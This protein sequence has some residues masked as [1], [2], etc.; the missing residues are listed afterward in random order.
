MNALSW[1]CC[2][3]KI[4]LGA[5]AHENIEGIVRELGCTRLFVAVDEALLEGELFTTGGTG[6]EVSGSCVITDTEKNLKM[7]IRHA[8]FN[9]ADVAILDPLA[10]RTLPAHVAA[11][12]ALTR[13]S[14][15]SKAT[16]RC[17]PTRSPTR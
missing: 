17:R 14:M 11:H 1:Y 15:R 12:S 7:S 5:G 8:Q 16:C 6:S 2:P 3:S 9:P 13:S 10:V 4:H